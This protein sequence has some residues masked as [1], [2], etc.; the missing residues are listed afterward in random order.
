MIRQRINLRTPAVD[1]L[2]RALT[3]LLALILFWYGLMV[4]LLAVKVS[5]HT[6]NSLS[7]YRTLYNDAASFKASDFTTA[8]RLIAGFTGLLV[9]VIFLYLAVQCRP[10]PYLARGPVA[11]SDDERGSVLVH[12][13]AIERVAELAAKGDPEVTAAAGRLGD[14]QLN[15]DVGLRRARFAATTLQDVHERVRTELQRHELPSLPVNVTLTGYDRQTRR[16]VL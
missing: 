14:R 16:E 13:R 12:P 6:V 10:R 2:V 11:L 8:R 4:V 1:Y 9:F 15:L 5:P 7:A 3:I